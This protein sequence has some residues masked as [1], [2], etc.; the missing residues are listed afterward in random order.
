MSKRCRIGWHDWSMWTSGANFRHCFRCGKKQQDAPDA[1]VLLALELDR[2]KHG[3]R[4][5]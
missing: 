3:D 5:A 4:G 1:S 2:L